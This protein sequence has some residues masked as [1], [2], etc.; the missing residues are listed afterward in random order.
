MPTVQIYIRTPNRFGSLAVLEE[1]RIR[2]HSQTI[3]RILS[4]NNNTSPRPQKQTVILEGA[5]PAALT[6]LLDRIRT[7]KESPN[8][9]IK[10]H[11]LS[12]PKAVAIWEAAE[13]LDLQPPQPHIQG[14]VIGYIA[15]AVL[16]PTE[17]G[18]LHRCF[19]PRREACKVWRVMVHQV[20]WCI[21]NGA[22]EEAEAVEL[23]VAAME[24][25]ELVEAVD[26]KIHEDL[27]PK[28]L[29]REERLARLGF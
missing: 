25:P 12:L 28:R 21:V 6:Y 10:V 7:N 1:K 17:M 20:A 22:Y 15:H 18:V 11:D 14:H 23:K 4:S 13:L 9:H 26:G 24:W 3:D 27:L 19:Y 8:L 29:A 16:T 5:A 2:T